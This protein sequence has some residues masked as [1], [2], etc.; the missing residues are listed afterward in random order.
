MGTLLS[1]NRPGR[2][3]RHRKHGPFR[4]LDRYY[5][6]TLSFVTTG[7]TGGGAS[8]ALWRLPG[9]RPGNSAGRTRSAPPG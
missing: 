8:A 3:S 6:G 9:G 2:R 1:G 7:G 4:L 5:R